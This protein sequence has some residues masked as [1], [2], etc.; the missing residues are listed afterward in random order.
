MLVNRIPGRSL[1][2][3]MGAICAHVS[4]LSQRQQRWRLM[5]S[6][7]IGSVN[8]YRHQSCCSTVIIA[9]FTSRFL[10]SA[11]QRHMCHLAR[12]LRS[13]LVC[14]S[15]LWRVPGNGLMTSGN[16][17]RLSQRTAECIPA[18]SMHGGPCQTNHLRC[19]TCF[20]RELTLRNA[21]NI[22][23]NKNDAIRS[24]RWS[25]ESCRT[26]NCSLCHLGH[27]FHFVPSLCLSWSIT[28][29]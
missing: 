25:R 11:W 10:W 4:E 24:Q 1:Q 18:C 27:T 19:F 17:Q 8:D 15:R 6:L 2:C 23:C 13:A 14:C 28:W 12:C 5:R 9:P 20:V 16:C 29:E 3:T 26:L 22:F 7:M 21:M